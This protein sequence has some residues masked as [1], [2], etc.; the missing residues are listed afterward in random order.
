MTSNNTEVES[1]YCSYC[2]KILSLVEEISQEFHN[3][4]HSE[5]TTYEED[6]SG[7]YWYY[8]ESI[9]ANFDDISCDHNG[10]IVSLDLS[11]KGITNIP[12]IDNIESFNH[13]EEINLS[14]NYLTRVPSWFY[15]LPSLKRAIFPGN[16]FSQSLLLDILKLNEKGLEVISTGCGFN[17]N[18]QLVQLNLSFLGSVIPLNLSEEITQHFTH[19]ERLFLRWNRMSSLPYWVLDLKHL[20][21]LNI[22]TNRLLGISSLDLKSKKIEKINLADNNLSYIPEW[23]RDQKNLVELDLANNRI[24]EIPD[25]LYKL[26]K[27]KILYV[28]RDYLSDEILYSSLKKLE[29]KGIE[30]SFSNYNQDFFWW[31]NE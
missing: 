2:R 3:T 16:G 26:R 19:L 15:K 1:T 28:S 24:E 11:R 21:E 7:K 8:L 29:K 14:E 31:G 25:E 18:N 9:K 30:V 4:C 23:V 12:E 5:I 13:L 22:S 10:N 20:K 6:K 27:L 17:Q